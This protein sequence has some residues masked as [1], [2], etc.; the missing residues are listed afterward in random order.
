M[1]DPWNLSRKVIISKLTENERVPTPEGEEWILDTIHDL[2]EELQSLKRDTQ[3]LEAENIIID[4]L[5]ALCTDLF[6][7]SIFL[8]LFIVCQVMT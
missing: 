3:D 5:E 8:Y 4:I 6:L 1:N 7:C 2:W